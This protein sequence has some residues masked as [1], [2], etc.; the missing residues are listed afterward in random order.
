MTRSGRPASPRGTGGRDR[1]ARPEWW[2][3]A[4]AGGDRARRR[5]PPFTCQLGSC[6]AVL[7]N[8]GAR[9]AAARV[10]VSTNREG[11]A[12]RRRWEGVVAVDEVIAG[13]AADHVAAEVAEERVVVRTSRHLVIEGT[14]ERGVVAG[15][16]GDA[17]DTAKPDELVVS[18][19]AVQ[20]VVAAEASQRV[21][22]RTAQQR[23][24][25]RPVRRGE[26]N[27]VEFIADENIIALAAVRVSLPP[28]P[29]TMSL[30]PPPNTLS[31]PALATMTSSPSVPKI[32]PAPTI[33]AGTSSPGGPHSG[34]S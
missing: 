16:A 32:V 4:K 19:S 34:A 27:A 14:T 10:V 22:S 8:V 25:V 23:V 31:F 1:L 6:L 24:V 9:T 29:Q 7:H 33:V 13:T 5:P 18:G 20:G 2:P 15:P 17:V 30:P 12:T 3:C 21:V 26:G 11:R 28:S